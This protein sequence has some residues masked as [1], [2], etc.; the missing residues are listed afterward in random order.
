MALPSTLVYGWR[1]RQT[2]FLSMA[3]SPST[4]PQA[5]P[6]HALKQEPNPH[7]KQEEEFHCHPICIQLIK[8]VPRS[9]TV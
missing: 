4:G 6:T 3:T 7:K 1:Y 2:K 8:R 5:E 9:S